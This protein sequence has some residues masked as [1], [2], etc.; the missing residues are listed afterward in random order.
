MPQVQSC[1]G[2][3]VESAT[4]VISGIGCMRSD[5]TFTANTAAKVKTTADAAMAIVFMGFRA[6]KNFGLEEER[7]LT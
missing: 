3:V 2:R 4:G 6:K 5:A 1:F 7:T